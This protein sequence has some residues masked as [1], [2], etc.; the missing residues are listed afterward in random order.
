MA[1]GPLRTVAGNGLDQGLGPTWV[2]C[3]HHPRGPSPDPHLGA[4]SD[5]GLRPPSRPSSPPPVK[6]LLSHHSLSHTSLTP[7]DGSHPPLMYSEGAVAQK[8]QEQEGRHKWE[9]K[10]GADVH[11]AAQAANTGV[12]EE[13]AHSGVEEEGE[14]EDP[15]SAPAPI[16]GVISRQ[17][18]LRILR[19]RAGFCGS[20][21][22]AAAPEPAAD[23]AKRS[24]RV[25]ASRIREAVEKLEAMPWKPDIT[26][27]GQEALFSTLTEPELDSFLN[28]RNFMQRVPYTVP[29]NASLGR[30]YRLC[31]CV[32]VLPAATAPL[33]LAGALSPGFKP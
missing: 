19:A 14:L 25:P 15:N 4:P 1:S 21:H 11:R 26:P 8:Q 12:G 23:D 16:V 27:R 17:T 24:A 33:S 10:G 31:R 13:G 28:L 32:Q 30:A 6:S 9:P 29:A 7:G 3:Q 2:H 20:I 5:L 18:V 22:E